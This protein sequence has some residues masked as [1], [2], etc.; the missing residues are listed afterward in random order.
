M[1]DY[2]VEARLTAQEKKLLIERFEN[3]RERMGNAT[4]QAGRKPGDVKLV[5]VSK[6]HPAEAVAELANYWTALGEQPRFGEN[7]MQEAEAKQ[8]AVRT[9]LGQNASSVQW[10]FIGHLQSKKAKQ[11]AG[12]FALIHSLDSLSL[13]QNLQKRLTES[14]FSH[15]TDSSP[16]GLLPGSERQDVLVQIN[17]GDET[18]KSGLAAAGAEAFIRSLSAFPALRVQGLMGMP[19]LFKN[20]EASRPYYRALRQ[21][22]E[23]LQKKLGMALPELSMGMSHDMEAAIKEGATIVRIGTDIFG[24]RP[25]KQELT[26]QD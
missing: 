21:L 20:G 2:Q 13:A 7:Y 18:Q 22:R 1:A 11:A 5:A 9:I 15:T 8:D 26:G 12:R 17:L 4:R 3:V 24:P 16:D 6:F 10:H 14:D 25:T 23:D 19:P